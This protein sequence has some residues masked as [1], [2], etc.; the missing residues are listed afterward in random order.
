MFLNQIMY[1]NFIE[2][3]RKNI[4]L[5]HLQEVFEVK[6]LEYSNNCLNG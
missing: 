1:E 5:Y 6:V 4:L 2:D 3:V